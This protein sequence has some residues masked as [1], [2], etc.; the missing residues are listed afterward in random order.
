M[1][2]H[3][4]ITSTILDEI[5]RKEAEFNIRNDSESLRN[6][7][8]QRN[9]HSRSFNVETRDMSVNTEPILSDPKF[10]DEHNDDID[11]DYPSVFSISETDDQLFSDQLFIN[12]EDFKSSNSISP[13]GTGSSKNEVS[14]ND[15]NSG[16]YDSYPS[17]DESSNIRIDESSNVANNESSNIR[18]D[19]SS[20]ML[21][22]FPVSENEDSEINFSEFTNVEKAA[23]PTQP[24]IATPTTTQT[25][26]TETTNTQSSVPLDPGSK[27]SDVADSSPIPDTAVSTSSDDY[28]NPILNPNSNRVYV[29]PQH[30]SVT[31]G[32]T[33]LTSGRGRS[34][35]I[36]R[37]VALSASS[38]QK[39]AILQKR[40]NGNDKRLQ[41]D[42]KDRIRAKRSSH[43]T[44]QVRVKEQKKETKITKPTIS[45][46]EENV[47]SNII[48]PKLL[49]FGKLTF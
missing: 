34:K 35:S 42:V 21:S 14:G 10:E 7:S 8:E 44:E 43:Q 39:K 16:Q 31:S 27:S 5:L 25:E 30:V 33:G 37:N 32:A 46:L 38:H 26:T 40:T 48:T 1:Q 9:Q 2:Q 13:T 28:F 29:P 47:N 23:S 36:S 19:E 11:Q 45:V 15:L 4:T 41:T 20:N 49:F 17:H 12:D 18:N 3:L 22:Q 6:Q 24:P